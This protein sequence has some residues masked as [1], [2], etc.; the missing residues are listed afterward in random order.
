M[1][2][3]NHLVCQVAAVDEDSGVAEGQLGLAEHSVAH[4]DDF[5]KQHPKGGSG[6]VPPHESPLQSLVCVGLVLLD[7]RMIGEEVARDVAG[8]DLDV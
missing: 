1:H 6:V 2:V 7:E 8:P 4:P 3:C 5:L